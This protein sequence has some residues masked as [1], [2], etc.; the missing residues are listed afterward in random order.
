MCR[1]RV[2]AW[3]PTKDEATENDA[4]FLDSGREKD[5]V[6]TV[7]SVVDVLSHFLQTWK[8]ERET[9]ARWGGS[10]LVGRRRRVCVCAHCVLIL[11]ESLLAVLLL[12][13]LER[14]ESSITA[15]AYALAHSTYF[16]GRMYSRRCTQHSSVSP[17]FSFLFFFN[18]PLFHE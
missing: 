12:L 15:A 9:G 1:H 2:P 14:R 17:V 5:V 16:K 4:C 8:R 11:L 6:D 18:P 13:L 7:A 3:H 10:G